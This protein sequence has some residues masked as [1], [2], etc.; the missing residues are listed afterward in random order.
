MQ[1]YLVIRDNYT[2]IAFYAYGGKQQILW[3]Y[4]K[5]ESHLKKM[6]C[7]FIHCIIFTCETKILLAP[8]SPLL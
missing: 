7:G 5:E 1:G 6:E 3:E 8:G 4:I 2:V